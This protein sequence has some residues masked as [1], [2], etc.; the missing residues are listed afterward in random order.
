MSLRRSEESRAR[1]VVDQEIGATTSMKDLIIPKS[2][3]GKVFSDF[4][5][6]DLMMAWI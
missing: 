1:V 4:A 5:E 3:A 6:L 2:I